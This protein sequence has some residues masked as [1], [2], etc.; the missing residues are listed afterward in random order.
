M[1]L[2]VMTRASLGHT[3]QPLAATRQIQLIYLAAVIAALARIGAAFGI[4]ISPML[5]LSATAW[6]L[7]FSGFVIVFAPLLLQRRVTN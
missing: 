5:Y 6:V 7:A 4:L 2:A 3:G 1:T